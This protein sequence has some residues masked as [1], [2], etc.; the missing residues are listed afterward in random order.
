ME[1]SSLDA[2]KISEVETDTALLVAESVERENPCIF[3]FQL[4]LG[5]DKP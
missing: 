5:R 3:C 1:H 4:S 2:S